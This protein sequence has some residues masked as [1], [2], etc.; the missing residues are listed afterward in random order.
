MSKQGRCHAH[1]FVH[2]CTWKRLCTHLRTT[3]TPA[4]PL[5]QLTRKPERAHVMTRS[6]RHWYMCLSMSINSG[7][8][9]YLPAMFKQLQRG[10]RTLCNM[11]WEVHE[12][13]STSTPGSGVCFPA[14][15]VDGGSGLAP[16]S[17]E[18]ND[19]LLSRP[20]RRRHHP[21]SS[22]ETN[23]VEQSRVGP[24]QRDRLEAPQGTGSKDIRKER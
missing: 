22:V 6:T 3:N 20:A 10:V 16:R 8:T 5:L 9:I 1:R 18:P 15:A 13:S 23:D 7:Q 12:A 14:A 21:P 24:A 4:P 17:L 2:K 11:L 19:P